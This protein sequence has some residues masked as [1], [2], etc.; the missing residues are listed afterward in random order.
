M[1]H[2]S[3][4]ATSSQSTGSRQTETPH[5]WTL[6]SSAIAGFVLLGLATVSGPAWN[7]PAQA[8]PPAVPLDTKHLW[9][10][11]A[12]HRREAAEASLQNPGPAGAPLLLEREATIAG[13][14]KAEIDA[15]SA[16][17]PDFAKLF[18]GAEGPSDGITMEGNDVRLVTVERGDTLAS[19]LSEAGAK[20]GD[21][22]GALAAL[23]GVYDP[24]QLRRGQRVLIELKPEEH[25][26]AP[27][28][29]TDGD[30][31]AL[32]DID[33]VVQ[34]DLVS[35]TIKQ[36]VEREITVR[37][38][39]ELK[40]AATVT[41][42]ELTAKPM[43]AASVIESSLYL[44]A[45]K[46]GVPESVTAE[47]IRL[48]SYDIDFQRQIQNGDS[49]EI[50]YDRYYDELAGP[51][52]DGEILYGALTLSGKA[53]R[54]YR[55]TTN[56]DDVTDYYD[57]NGESA[58][59]A[60][61]RTPIDGAR[62]S[63]RFGMRR[64]PILGYSRMHK[65][66]DFA[67]PTGTPIVAA[68]NGTVDFAGRNNGYGNYVRLNH[69]NGFQT[70][71]AHMSRFGQGIRRGARVRQGQVIGYV[72]T[73]GLSSGPHLHYEVLKAHS[74]ID[75]TSV[76]TATGRKLTGGQLRAFLREKTRI[77]ELIADKPL[78]GPIATLDAIAPATPV[79]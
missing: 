42:R 19:L 63:S 27:R 34:R 50:Y 69:D 59:K 1:T 76:R 32:T 48:F 46:V 55:F 10:A 31:P 38:D 35:V 78:D 30:A 23:K 11:I 18:A 14:A 2:P 36:S 49:F 52:K 44:S 70:A 53:Y 39:A 26:A 22:Q 71:Y 9:E 57:E 28:D 77:D 43:Y 24:R 75:P 45:A 21:V 29:E 72:G 65:G 60:L 13:E 4:P 16:V 74:Q 64:H 67:A 41:E 61:L 8:S 51:V 7:G 12:D 66:I 47:L 73:T 17:L 62:I 37:R 20:D 5:I 15:V 79:P 25:A 3:L 54:L 58:R 56:D 68:G 33:S 40:F 6:A